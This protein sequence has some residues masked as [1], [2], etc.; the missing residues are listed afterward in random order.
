MIAEAAKRGEVDLSLVSINST[1]ARAH[2]DAAGIHLGEDVVT[3]L[4]KVAAEEDKATSGG[5][6]QSQAGREA[7]SDPAREERR[8]IRAG[9]RTRQPPTHPAG[10]PTADKAYSSCRSR[11]Q[12]RKRRIKAVSLFHPVYWQVRRVC[13]AATVLPMRLVEQR[14]R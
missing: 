7:E 2:H 10:C 6:P 5:A 4:E 8:R 3:A 14:A 1:T 13:T 9:V 12:L 11:T